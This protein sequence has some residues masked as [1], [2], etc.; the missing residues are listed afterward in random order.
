MPRVLGDGL[1]A[2]FERGRW[3]IP[4]IFAEV[5]RVGGVDD[6][7]MARVF[8]LGLGMVVAVAPGEVDA[9]AEALAA[10]GQNATV[11]GGLISG[12]RQVHLTD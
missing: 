7:E 1:D 5:Q 4:P 8:N 12:R 2:V 3:N 9:A 11:V 10:A 6:D